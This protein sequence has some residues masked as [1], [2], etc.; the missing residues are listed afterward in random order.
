VEDPVAGPVLQQAP[1]PRVST[2]PPAAP[3][4]APRLGEHNDEVW[5]ALL[6]PEEYAQAR[7][8]GII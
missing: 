7:D 1:Y 6:S 5:G 3:R 8:A 4:G 2:V